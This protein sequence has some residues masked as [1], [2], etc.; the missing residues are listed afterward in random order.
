MPLLRGEQRGRRGHRALA[1]ATLAREEQAAAIEQVGRGPVHDPRVLAG[2]EADLASAGI[3]SNLDVGDLVDRDPDLA[4]LGVGEPQ[5]R[6]AVRDRVSMVALTVSAESSVSRVSSRA[7]Y[8]TPMRTSM[9]T[10][11]AV[12][13]DDLELGAVDALGRELDVERSAIARNTCDASSSGSATTIGFTVVAA[14]A[15]LRHERHLAEQRHLELVG[16][17]LAAA[18]AEEPVDLAVIATEPRHVLDHAD[19]LAG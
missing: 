7:V 13:S 4:A 3:G 9:W 17:L 12:R 6:V 2:A 16:E 14:G 5:Q 1:D 18:L 10:R 11:L 15:Q 19:H 8:T